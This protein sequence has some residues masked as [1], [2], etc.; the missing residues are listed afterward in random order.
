MKKLVLLVALSLSGLSYGQAWENSGSNN[1]VYVGQD[2]NNYPIYKNVRPF[3]SLGS[4]IA[5]TTL[6]SGISAFFTYMIIDRRK[7]RKAQELEQEQHPL[8]QE[9]VEI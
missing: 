3:E 1:S 5:M 8:I 6:V 4:K 2:E 9:N 7:E